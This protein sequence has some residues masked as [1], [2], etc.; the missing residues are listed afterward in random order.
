MDHPMV[1]GPSNH[2]TAP[3][4][5]VMAMAGSMPPAGVYKIWDQFDHQGRILTFLFTI[6]LTT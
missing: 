1:A 6:W 5:T 2:G 3:D 4:T